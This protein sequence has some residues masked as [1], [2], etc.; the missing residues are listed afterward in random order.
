MLYIRH[1][2]CLENLADVKN[3]TLKQL[4]YWY[5][6]KEYPIHFYTNNYIS[7][8]VFVKGTVRQQLNTTDPYIILDK[9]LI[10]SGTVVIPTFYSTNNATANHLIIKS[11]GKISYK[12]TQ[13]D[14]NHFAYMYLTI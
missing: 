14:H 6:N 5:G 13:L 2:S 4:V 7:N 12:G 8:L 11:D 3:W 1:P 9:S 10:P